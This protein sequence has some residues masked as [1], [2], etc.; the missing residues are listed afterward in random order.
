MVLLKPVSCI[1][2]GIK[3]ARL[4]RHPATGVR[5]GRFIVSLLPNAT[6]I[7]STTGSGPVKMKKMYSMGSFGA[8]ILYKDSAIL[9]N[10]IQPG[11]PADIRGMRTGDV[12]I[13]INDRSIPD[14]SEFFNVLSQFWPGDTIIIKLKRSG[15]LL[16]KSITLKPVYIPQSEHPADHFEGGPSTIRDGFDK[17]FTHDAILHPEMCGGPVYDSNGFFCGINIARHS[18]ASTLTMPASVV[19]Y[20]IEEAV[21]S[22]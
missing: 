11:S 10:K 16:E 5:A 15:A 4:R 19:F 9:L 1:K 18:R 21:K 14:A 17:V 22:N 8:G 6:G 7:C 13:S 12:L 2:G 3:F 20:F